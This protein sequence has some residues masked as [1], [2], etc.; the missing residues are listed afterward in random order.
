[1]MHSSV[2]AALRLTV[3]VL[4]ALSLS[5]CD[6]GRD[7]LRSYIERIKARPAQPLGTATTTCAR[8][9]AGRASHW[10]PSPS[11]PCAW[12]EWSPRA[13]YAMH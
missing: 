9:R 13:A 10:K 7:D 12:S 4:F 6:D 8:I 2:T 1:M 5:A 11:M 3:G